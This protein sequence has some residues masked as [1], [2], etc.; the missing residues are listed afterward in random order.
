MMGNVERVDPEMMAYTFN[1]HVHDTEAE[2]ETYL[3]RFMSELFGLESSLR[4]YFSD[5]LI[6]ELKE[7]ITQREDARHSHAVVELI[8]QIEEKW[9]NDG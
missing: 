4:S 8:T 3:Q 5:Q 2:P 1:E 7:E 6:S 9:R